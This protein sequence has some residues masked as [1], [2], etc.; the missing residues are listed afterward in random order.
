MTR[1]EYFGGFST[2]NVC[3]NLSLNIVSLIFKFF[4]WRC[5]L[6]F[7][8]PSEDESIEFAKS[9]ISTFFSIN[10]SFRDTWTKTEINFRF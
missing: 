9:Y 3:R 7:R 5:K 10:N 1:I 6:R 8:L 2:N 4:V